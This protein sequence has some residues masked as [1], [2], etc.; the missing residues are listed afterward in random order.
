VNGYVMTR[1]ERGMRTAPNA[2]RWNALRSRALTSLVLW[3]AV[4]LAG[5]ALVNS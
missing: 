2:A 5:V 4:L 1:V 3:F